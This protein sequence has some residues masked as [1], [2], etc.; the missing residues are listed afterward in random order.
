MLI[1][2]IMAGQ[3]IGILGLGCS[4]M[5][6]AASLHAAGV[7]IFAYDDHKLDNP[8]EHGTLR[9]WQ[10]WPWHDLDALVI[11][12]GI[13]H[14]HPT[15]HPA[16]AR[17]AAANIEILSEVE[18]AMRAVPKA[19]VVVITG[20]NG[21]STTTAL[22]SHCLQ[23]VGKNVAV[24]GNIG[25]AVCS[26]DDPGPDGVIVLELSSF[27]LETT[28]SLSPN[29]AVVLNITPDHLDR[30][31]GMAGYVAAKKRALTALRRN[32]TAI[33]GQSN[34]Y[35]KQLADL[36]KD[37][38]IKTLL[39]M[40][41]EAPAGRDYCQALRGNHNAENAAAAGLVLHCLGLNLDQ[42]NTSM[43]SF[44]GLPHRLQTVATMGPITFVNDSKATNG[45][46]AA[47]AVASYS[48]IYWI[49]G[50]QAKEDGLDA[51]IP[52][53]RNVAKAYLIGTSAAAFAEKLRGW[54]HTDIYDNLYEAIHA[55]F[56]DAK[57]NVNGGT[58]LL[59]PAAASFDQ[60]DN[61]G[62]RGDE[63]CRLAKKLCG[64]KVKAD[65]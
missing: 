36:C 41:D 56:D 48:Q 22:V 2:H 19:P 7:S 31:A 60:F 17:A 47:K 51:V 30:H 29:I 45:S 43:A 35:V 32:G 8:F 26:L 57:E 53:I 10:D 4:G 49:A 11:S 52:H 18:I 55:A 63:F 34:D 21:K 42:I 38:G 6:A 59:A 28:L 46:A 13:P 58:I 9:A 39:A 5:A 50:G 33:I 62:A 24:G 27:Q 44:A 23:E 25:Q 20:T 61:F 1:P 40:P 64:Q 37:R 16:A 12:P 54:C 3:T 65:V 14:L 15:P